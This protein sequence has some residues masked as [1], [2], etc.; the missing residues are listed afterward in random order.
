MASEYGEWKNIGDECL[1]EY[2]KW[3]NEW[4]YWMGEWMN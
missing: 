2:I 1:N 3:V 4:I